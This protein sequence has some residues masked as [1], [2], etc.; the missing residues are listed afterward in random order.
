MNESTRIA[1]HCQPGA[2]QSQVVGWHD[3]RI[4]VQLKAPPVDGKANAAL[5]AFLADQLQLP[6]SALC[7]VSG[8]T[9][10]QKRVQVQGLSVDEVLRRLGLPP[11][12]SQ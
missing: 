3:G 10:R 5:L 11:C 9:Q 8:D 1:L 2:K 6:K 4:K 7:L 12:P